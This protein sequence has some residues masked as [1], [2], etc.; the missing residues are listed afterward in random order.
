MIH[1]IVATCPTRRHNPSQQTLASRYATI[2]H[3]SRADGFDYGG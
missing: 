2:A 1:L 3:N